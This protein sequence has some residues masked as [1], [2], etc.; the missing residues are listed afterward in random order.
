MGGAGGQTGTGGTAGLR[1]DGAAPDDRGGGQLDAPVGDAGSSGGSGGA[2]SDANPDT[3][4]DTGACSTG[5]SL[6]GGA[7][8]NLS[9]DPANC[10]S[11]GH[12]CLDPPAGG[13]GVCLGAAG[14]GVR[15]AN[16]S[17]ACGG[18]CCPDAPT[19]AFAT[20]PQ[21][22]QCGVQCN[23]TFHACNGTA[24]PCFSDQDVA[25]CGAGCLD[26]RQPNATPVC[27][28]NQCANACVGATLSCPGI[29]GKPNCGSWDFES[30][31]AEGWTLDLTTDGSFVASDGTIASSTGRA[32]TAT[33]SLALGFN[34][35]GTSKN[36][37]RIMVPLCSGGQAIDLTNKTFS[38]RVSLARLSGTTIPAH[39]GF[40]SAYWGPPMALTFIDFEF[41]DSGQF[42]SITGTFSP[43][44]AN[45][46]TYI[47]LMFGIDV[48]WTGTIYIDDIEI[49]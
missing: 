3:P 49:R 5:M 42:L 31:T 17:P 16:G 18:T 44:G 13:S 36:V 23:A 28:G 32:S 46:S 12:L 22:N 7:C 25:H 45:A 34:G 21:P 27:G 43:N 48:P 26:C 39:G 10:G 41:D 24:S 2:A 40:G 33:H 4:A 47:G 37:V 11:C 8:T 19:N 30:G 38:M 6:C 1:A 20:C 14:C 9:T 29:A 35:D 15:C